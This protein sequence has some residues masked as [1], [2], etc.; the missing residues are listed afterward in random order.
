MTTQKPITVKELKEL[1][2]A[3]IKD[4][5]WDRYVFLSNDDEWNW[6][7]PLW[8]TFLTDTQ[9]IIDADCYNDVED[10]SL[11]FTEVVFLG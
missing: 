4:W 11:G 7:H 6:R 10:N 9:D 3:V 5:Y 1:C 2:E 8:F